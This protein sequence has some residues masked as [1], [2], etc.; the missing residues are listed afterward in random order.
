MKTKLIAGVLAGV[1][2]LG[3]AWAFGPEV[4]QDLFATVAEFVTGGM[5]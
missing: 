4:A 3:A 1:F 5:E 2:L